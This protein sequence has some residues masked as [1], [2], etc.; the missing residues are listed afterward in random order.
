M[1]LGE[2]V[3]KFP[4]P[5]ALPQQE[6]VNKPE[7][8]DKSASGSK[9]DGKSDVTPVINI[10]QEPMDTSESGMAQIKQE[11]LSG[12]PSEKKLKLNN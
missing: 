1:L 10:K 6:Q 11:P 7:A 4:I 5:Q 2:M 8:E 9:N 3:R 12:A